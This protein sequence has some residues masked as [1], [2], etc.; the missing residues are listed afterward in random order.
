[1]YSFGTLLLEMFTAKKPTDEIFKEGLSLSKYLSAMDENEMVKVVD[2]R[3]IDGYEYWKE[4]SSSDDESGGFRGKTHWMDKA[5]ECIADVIRL[6]LCCTADQL[7]E[8]WSM[9]DA[10]SKLQTIKHNSPVLWT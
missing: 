4:S 7:K 5:E 10:S 8:R 2:R 3:V 1:M 6:G 9:R